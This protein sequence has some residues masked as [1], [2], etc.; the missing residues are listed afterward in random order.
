MQSAC[1]KR[2][3]DAYILTVDGTGNALIA[4]EAVYTDVPGVHAV[5]D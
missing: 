3:Q 4:A 5:V 2:K 1:N